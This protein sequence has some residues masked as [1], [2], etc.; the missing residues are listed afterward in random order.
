[1]ASQEAI[2]EVACRLPETLL[3][4]SYLPSLLQSDRSR[5]RSECHGD[6]ALHSCDPYLLMGCWRT[7]ICWEGRR[8]KRDDVASINLS[9]EI[10]DKEEAAL[11]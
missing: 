9:L 10:K 3:Q 2:L 6:L 7:W 1:M 11:A 4:H 8:L 5:D